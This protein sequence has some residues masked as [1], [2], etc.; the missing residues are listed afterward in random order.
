MDAKGRENFWSVLTSITDDNEA[1]L[2]K[3]WQASPIQESLCRFRAVS[4]S[5]LLQLQENRQYFS[6]ANYYDDPFDTYFKVDTDRIQKEY[7]GS[8]MKLSG[9]DDGDIRKII[10]EQ[11]FDRLSTD[12]YIQKLKETSLDVSQL[13]FYLNGLRNAVQAHTASIC[14]CESAVNETM[15]MKYADCH[16]GFVQVYDFN[17]PETFPDADE[18]AA[19][20]DTLRRRVPYLFPVYYSDEKY[21]ATLF[22]MAI[23]AQTFGK[24]FMEQHTESQK[25]FYSSTMWQIERISL[26][27]KH[28]HHYD[29]EWRMLYP[30]QYVDRPYI[31]LKPCRVIIG[32]RTPKIEERLI[33]S[34]AKIASIKSLYKICIDKNNELGMIKIDEA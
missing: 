25:M 19:G 20:Q 12:D 27:K 22:A 14:F 32:L 8:K 4:C 5:S 13:S 24:Q 3:L 15:W 30:L 18:I 1:I 21:D 29:E 7:E 16:K 33:I 10:D 26:I 11:H 2:K 23:S 28:C 17:N 31:E 6:T 9:G 34:A